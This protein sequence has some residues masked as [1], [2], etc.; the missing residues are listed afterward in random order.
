M[1]N[2]NNYIYINT[3]IIRTLS[4]CIGLLTF[5]SLEVV[6]Q[7]QAD[8]QLAHEYLLK[9][10][11]RKALELYRE[12]AKN[13]ANLPFIQNNYLNTLLDLSETDEALAH[14]KKLLKRNPDNVLYKIDV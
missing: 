7:N 13:D 9:G 4:L 2:N 8:I 5:L 10:E 1:T 12:L 6:S 3:L 14:L 11:K